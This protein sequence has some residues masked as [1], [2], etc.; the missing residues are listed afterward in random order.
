MFSNPK[1][2]VVVP[3][4]NNQSTIEQCL[5]AL[6]D[7]SY[8]VC[9]IIVVDDG[10]TDQSAALVAQF[11]CILIKLLKNHGVAFAR[12]RGAEIARGDLLFFTDGDV[13]VQKDTV[14]KGV[15]ALWLHPEVS[16]VMGSYALKCGA[17]NF[18]SV[19]RNIVHHYTH[20]MASPYPCSFFGACG[21]IRKKVF[22]AVGG[23]SEEQCSRVMEDVYLGYRLCK[24]GYKIFLEKTMQVVHLKKHTFLGLLY[25]DFFL[26]AVPWTKFVFFTRF[27]KFNLC[28]KVSDLLSLVLVFLIAVVFPLVFVFGSWWLGGVLALL[29]VLFGLLNLQLCALLAAVHG[30]MFSLASLGMRYLYFVSGGIGFIVGSISFLVNRKL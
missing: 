20:Q 17:T 22:D 7:S 25:S 29:I 10:S 9:E 6:L 28:T 15:Q 11:P 18:C 24:R 14:A 21:M 8:K 27:V 26:R 23:F 12:N 16:A 1:V 3:V 2:S 4:Y 30:M 13:V 5:R 19:Y